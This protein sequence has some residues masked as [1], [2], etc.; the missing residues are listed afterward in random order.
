MRLMIMFDLPTETSE[1]RRNYRHFRKDL[2]K[3]GFF[4]MQYSVYVKVCTSRQSAKFT[5]N[6]LTVLAPKEG[7]VQSFMLTERQYQDMKFI[8]GKKNDD[9]INSSDR[10]LIL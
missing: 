1:Q 4:M 5:E 7:L 10:T 8:S 2:L 6:R 9:V 3:E